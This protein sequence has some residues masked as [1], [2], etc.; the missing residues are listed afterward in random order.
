[1]LATWEARVLIGGI[2]SGILAGR[3]A[4]IGMIDFTQPVLQACNVSF[5]AAFSE[6]RLLPCRDAVASVR[7]AAADRLVGTAKGSTKQSIARRDSTATDEWD[8]VA[9]IE[10]AATGPLSWSVPAAGATL[11]RLFAGMLAG[12]SATIAGRA[13]LARH[14]R[15]RNELSYRR[16]LHS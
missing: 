15:D 4:G 5:R 8:R 10:R 11:F 12:L 6:V 7:T 9:P 3:A 13:G 14:R 1:G 2:L 16:R